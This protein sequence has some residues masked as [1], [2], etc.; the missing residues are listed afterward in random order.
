MGDESTPIKLNEILDST[1][2]L[3]DAQR[4]E[5][6]IKV[7]A[8]QREALLREIDSLPD[9]SPLSDRLALH[10]KLSAITRT[11]IRML[12]TRLASMEREKRLAGL[13]D[14]DYVVG[15]F[16][17]VVK[18]VV[19]ETA[20]CEIGRRL[21]EAVV[22][23]APRGKALPK[24]TRRRKVRRPAERVMPVRLEN[25]DR[26]RVGAKRSPRVRTIEDEK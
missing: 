12:D 24:H 11:H 16:L 3:Q 23:S 5:R 15:V 20:A 25:Q 9:D 8:A 14:I 4:P 17:S 10:Q 13:T 19:G 1:T 22:A 6:S 21:G 18:D 7:L 2:L 26:T